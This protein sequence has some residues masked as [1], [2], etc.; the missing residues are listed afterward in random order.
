M[1]LPAGRKIARV[2][3][4]RSEKTVAFTQ[5]GNVVEF[6]VPGVVDYEGAALT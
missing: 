2:E 5:R 6:K 3:L 1:R 4:L